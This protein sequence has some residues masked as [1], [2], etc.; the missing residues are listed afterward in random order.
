MPSVPPAT[1][2]DDAFDQRL[3]HQPGLTGAER[4]PMA[5]SRVRPAARASERLARLTIS[6]SK[7][8][9]TARHHQHQAP[10]RTADRTFHQGVHR[11]MDVEVTFDL[12]VDRGLQHLHL[13]LRAGQ[14]D[15]RL[16]PRRG[17]VVHVAEADLQV[18]GFVA[19]RLVD[20]DRLGRAPAQPHGFPGKTK[21]AGATPMTT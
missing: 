12:A 7:T 18:A 16:E 20:L 1:A 10:A 13:R 4:G 5:A 3:P 11:R 9:P 6:T 17:P 21:D 14:R 19:E 2:R 15:S 8:A